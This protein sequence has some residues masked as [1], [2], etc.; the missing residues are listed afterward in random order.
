MSKM[1]KMNR[2]DKETKRK[3]K[4]KKVQNMFIA[5]GVWIAVIYGRLGW[6]GILKRERERENKG[7]KK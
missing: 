5:I 2:G 1:S 3:K 4:K 7:E 6:Y